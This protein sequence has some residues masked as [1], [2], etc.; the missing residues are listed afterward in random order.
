MKPAII[1][2]TGIGPVAIKALAEHGIRSLAKLSR[3]SVKKIA[4][5]PGFSK[6]RATRTIADAAELLAATAAASPDKGGKSASKGK[7]GGKGKK[8]R[9]GKEKGKGKGKNKKDG[10]NRKKRG[11][12]KGKSKDKKKDKK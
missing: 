7:A 12:N 5:I 3:A 10:K 2:I 9:K 6:A 8:G 1:N 11:K 4:S